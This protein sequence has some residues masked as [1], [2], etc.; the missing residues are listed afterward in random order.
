MSFIIFIRETL[1]LSAHGFADQATAWG[2]EGVEKFI[3]VGTVDER[4]PQLSATGS[5]LYPYSYFL[6]CGNTGL[7]HPCGYES[8]ERRDAILLSLYKASSFNFFDL[9]K[10]DSPEEYDIV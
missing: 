5:T 7:V 9:L 6:S 3:C 8:A 4:V 10:Q 1:A 2:S